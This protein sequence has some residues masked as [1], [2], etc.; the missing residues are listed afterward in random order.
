MKKIHLF[1]VFLF[2]LL[3]AASVHAHCPLCTIAIGGMAMSA[4]F[5]GIDYSIVG[6]FIG[7]FGISTGLWIGRKLKNYFQFQLPLV[8]LA[9]FALTVIPLMYISDEN[10]FF[11]MLLFGEVGT[12]FNKFYWLNKILFGSLLG[13]F[14]SLGSFW[15]H[16]HIKRV[17]GK[18]LF[19]YQGIA[20]T[21]LVLAAAA[22][23]MF[24][25]IG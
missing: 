15:L 14:F 8:V 12:I 24:F 2:V 22:A 18:V 25:L 9:S 7:A 17:N 3:G 6:L 23:A 19:P 21:V 20:L 5:F 1:S 11:P 4:K 16:N 13:G 10:V